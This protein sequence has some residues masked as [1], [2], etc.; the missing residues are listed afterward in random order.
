VSETV[1]LVNVEYSQIA[2]AELR[3]G[4]LHDLD[5]ESDNRFLGN[6]YQGRVIAFCQVWM[7]RSL[8]LV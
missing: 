8:T 5:I 1:L 2:V 3:D 4:V 6:I 7:P